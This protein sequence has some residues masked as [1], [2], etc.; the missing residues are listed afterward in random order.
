MVRFEGDLMGAGL[1]IGKARAQKL[2]D[3]G[4]Q[5]LVISHEELAGK[6]LAWLW[7]GKFYAGF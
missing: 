3:Q 4:V 2:V 7:N 6:F 5:Q 1:K